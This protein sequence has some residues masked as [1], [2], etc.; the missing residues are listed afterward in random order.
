MLVSV[1]ALASRFGYSDGVA[2]VVSKA[3]IEND[4]DEFM[5]QAK[6]PAQIIYFLRVFRPDREAMRRSR[7]IKLD[8]HF[9]EG[10]GWDLGQQDSHHD[11]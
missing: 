8:K 5:R 4:F 1:M 9:V 6:H 3:A 11:L 10:R 7:Q 2:Y